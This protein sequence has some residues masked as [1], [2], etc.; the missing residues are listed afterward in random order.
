MATSG[1][2]SIFET[3]RYVFGTNLMRN[4]ASFLHTS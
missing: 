3:E 1:V 4:D 2:T